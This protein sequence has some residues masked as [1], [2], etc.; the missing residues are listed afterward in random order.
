MHLSQPG[1]DYS[2]HD[3]K[4]AIILRLIDG[5]SQRDKTGPGDSDLQVPE[6]AAN[7]LARIRR[8]CDAK[9]SH[10]PPR[11]KANGQTSE[12]EHPPQES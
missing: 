8:G 10:R 1:R 5:S 2:R 7:T 3:Q 9:R 4:E 11:T 12:R 6:P